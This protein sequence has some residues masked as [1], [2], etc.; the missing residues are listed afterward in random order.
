MR[1]QSLNGL[2][3]ISVCLLFSILRRLQQTLM[4]PPSGFARRK[5]GW[6]LILGSR[7]LG[8]VTLRNLGPGPL[9]PDVSCCCDRGILGERASLPKTALSCAVAETG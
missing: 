7:S 1:G 8:C 9:P 2:L 5:G 4:K 3:T 6:A